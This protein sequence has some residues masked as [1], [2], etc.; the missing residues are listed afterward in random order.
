MIGDVF[1]S[2]E[3]YLLQVEGYNEK[4]LHEEGIFSPRVGIN[5]IQLTTSFPLPS[6]QSLTSATMIWSAV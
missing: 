5:Y 4:T 1:T 3:K 6:F 2:E